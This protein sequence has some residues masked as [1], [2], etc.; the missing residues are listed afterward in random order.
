[1]TSR[2]SSRNAVI[3]A[4]Y[5][6]VIMSTTSLPLLPFTVVKALIAPLLL[7]SFET[8]QVN[9]P[10]SISTLH[11]LPQEELVTSYNRG[12]SY[13]MMGDFE[14]ALTSF[15]QAAEL[16]PESEDVYLSRGIVEEKLLKWDD[17][18]ADYNKANTIH[19]KRPFTGDDPTVISNI[20]NAE[21]GLLQW[22]NA[23]R[24]FTRAAQM[25]S[26]FLAPQIGR[27]LVLYQLD[28]PEETFQYFKTIAVKYPYFPDGQA[29][30]AAIYFEKGDLKQANDC[31]ENALEEDSRYLDL[32]WV[33]N[34]RR[35]PPKLV[36]TLTKFKAQSSASFAPPVEME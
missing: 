18:I 19:K 15:N 35:W 2:N 9:I 10:T 12:N 1:M 32:D 26:D 13:L 8:P 22:E 17:A 20:A 36:D 31:W 7:N 6:F 33:L 14:N 21:T 24:D 27:A 16:A 5:F 3:T 25:K 4:S 29:V 23:L 28:R 11:P 30:L 34:I